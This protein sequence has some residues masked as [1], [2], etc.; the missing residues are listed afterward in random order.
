MTSR[1]LE[2]IDELNERFLNL[3]QVT[4]LRV[5]AAWGKIS[6]EEYNHLFDT[7]K[8]LDDILT[9]FSAFINVK[10]PNRP[11]L[12]DRWNAIDFNTKIRGFRVKT[13]DPHTI[14]SCWQDGMSR[15]RALLKSIRAE[16]V[17]S[18]DDDNT[19]KN[20]SNSTR[21]TNIS[22][23]KVIINEHQN[24]GN[25]SLSDNALTSPTIQTNKTKS[26]T[27]GKKER[28]W[29]EV[30]AWIAAI[31]GTIIAFISLIK[32]LNWV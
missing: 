17:L 27:N 10:F 5:N 22:G 31:I 11:D 25:Q 29:L 15:L 9:E 18:I 16:V 8:K 14:E 6:E 24:F 23:G 30:S 21:Q 3:P 19:E 28:S 13:N 4:E 1:D 12:I 32:Y 20:N 7:Y 2:I 26:K